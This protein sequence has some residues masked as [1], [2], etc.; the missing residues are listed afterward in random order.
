MKLPPFKL[1]RYFDRYEFKV[2]HLLSSSDCQSMT[3]AELLALEPGSEPAFQETWLGYTEAPGHPALREAI[4]ALYEGIT[5]EQ[6]LVHAG[7]EEAIFN[8]MQVLT[9]PGDHVIVQTPCYQS[10]FDVAQ[11]AGAEVT[12]WPGRFDG[13]W[14]FD[15]DS[16]EALIHPT[17]RLVVVNAPHNPTGHLFTRSELDRLVALSQSHGFL[18]FSDEVYRGLEP[19]P[20]LRL[21]ALCDL[22]DRGLS[23]GVLSKTYGLAGLRI[24][25]IATRNRDVIRDLTSMKDY[26][27]ICNS[28]PSEFL[29]TVALRHAEALAEK[30]RQIIDRNLTL[31]D[32]FFGRHADRFVWRRPVAGPIAFPRVVQNS[33]GPLCQRLVDEAGVLLLPGGLYGPEF[34]AHFRI[35]FGRTDLPESLAALERGLSL[36]D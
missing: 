8:A 14:S 7:A 4:A 33:A 29:A 26:T 17:T 12:A 6:V 19:R 34:E 20:K 9:R 15:L 30:N 35:G 5:P 2:R 25:W 21:P 18:L 11:A 32:S 36:W 13:G 10:L 31:L 27:S 23:L 1:E 22:D 3:I 28:A 24:G 16:L